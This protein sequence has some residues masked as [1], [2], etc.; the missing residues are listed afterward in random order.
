MRRRESKEPGKNKV[1]EE[2]RRAQS[3]DCA[4]FR[5][6]SEKHNFLYLAGGQTFLSVNPNLPVNL[7]VIV[8]VNQCSG[9]L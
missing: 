2:R 5:R 4:D 7:N 9:S 8:N 1:K 6:F 3:A